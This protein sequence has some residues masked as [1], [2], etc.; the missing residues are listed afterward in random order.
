MQGTGTSFE[1]D[2]QPSNFLTTLQKG[3]CGYL[4]EPTSPSGRDLG[5]SKWILN[6]W[7]DI[8]IGTK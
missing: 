8:N 2:E 5:R 6:P 7:G 3:L 1:A 4:V